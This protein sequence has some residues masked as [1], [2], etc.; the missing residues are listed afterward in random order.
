MM[1]TTNDISSTGRLAMNADRRPPT[2]APAGQPDAAVSGGSGGN[3]SAAYRATVNRTASIAYAAGKP[4]PRA[5]ITPASSGPAT[6]PTL[7][8]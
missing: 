6:M 1:S 8:R 4:R 2:A 5:M 7:L 3:R